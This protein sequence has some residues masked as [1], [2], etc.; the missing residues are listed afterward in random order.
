MDQRK[1]WKTVPEGNV[2][3]FLGQVR[4]KLGG[5]LGV[6]TMLIKHGCPRA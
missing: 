1:E 5:S 4:P 3:R 2:G 6:G